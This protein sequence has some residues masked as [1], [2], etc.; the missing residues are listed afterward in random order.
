MRTAGSILILTILVPVT[1]VGV[2]VASLHNHILTAKFITHEL[3]TRDAYGIAE[4]Q[5]ALHIGDIKL[6]NVPITNSDVQALA[7][8][9]FPASWLQSNVEMI[10]NR[11]FSWFN[12]PQQAAL[13]L[14]VDLREPKSQLIPGV[15]TLIQSAL[16]R[17]PECPKRGTTADICKTKTTTVAEV[18]DQLKK[19]GIDLDSVT[20]QLPDSF[21]LLNPVLP[22]IKLGN[23]TSSKQNDTTTQDPKKQTDQK[24]DSR[25]TTSDDTPEKSLQEQATTVR[26]NLA[27]AR[28]Q[29]Q[30]G[31]RYALYTLLGYLVLIAGFV[32]I[33]ANSW[34]R[35]TRWSGILLVVMS[36]LPLAAAIASGIVLNRIIPSI[37][38][39][40]MP[41]EIQAAIIGALH[42]VQH[43]L[44]FPVLIGG[45]IALT[46]GLTAII[47]ASF[48]A[49]KKKQT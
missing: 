8:R 43:G 49:V 30:R 48:I 3:R 35:V 15:E 42:D 41:A 26:S 24:K 37:S 34:R 36:V 14:P 22:E 1:L 29:Y 27:T 45:S 47:G 12:D 25:Q 2:I 6:E 17:L 5:I 39:G 38:F 10:I 4:R 20:T 7:Q 11:S 31:L 16:P 9:V 44:F 40:T 21:D 28:D 19:N 18:K 32:A 33:N 46:L 23:A 13:S